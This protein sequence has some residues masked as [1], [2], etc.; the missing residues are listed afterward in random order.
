MD[1]LKFVLLDVENSEQVDFI[2]INQRDPRWRHLVCPQGP[3]FPVPAESLQL[4]QEE[5][6]QS[7]M[8]KEHYL[9]KL[10]SSYIGDIS[11]MIDPP[12]LF[13]KEPG[14]GWL[15]IGLFDEKWHGTGIAA[16]AME[17][18]EDRAKKRNL[19]RLE[20]GVFEFNLRSQRF[21]KKCGYVEIG[22]IPDFTFYQ[23]KFWSDLRLEKRLA[24]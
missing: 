7:V 24:P 17:F 14:S 21:A 8:E 4:F 20:L 3:R 13:K 11:L 1:N 6:R 23:N 22:R 16:L 2:F 18:I 10:E 12:M 5:L 9:I 19:K 15:G